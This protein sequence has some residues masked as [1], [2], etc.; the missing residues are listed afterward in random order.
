MKPMKPK[1]PFVFAALALLGLLPHIHADV[2]PNPLFSDNAVLQRDKKVQVWGVAAD[3]EKVTVEFAGQKV[4]TVAKDGKW[5]VELQQMPASAEPRTMTISGNNTITA[6]N[7]L[8]GEVWLCS[9]QSNMEWALENSTNGPEAVAAS[10]DPQLRMMRLPHRASDEPQSTFDAK[11]NACTPAS[12]PD[13]SAVA[14]HFGRDLRKSLGVP[15]GLIGSYFG[16]T[17]AESWTDRKTLETNPDLKTILEAH[18]RKI[19]EFDPVKMEETNKKNQADYEAALAKATAEG[20]K[21]PNRPVVLMPPTTDHRRPVGLYNGMIA[22]LQPYAIRGMIWYQGESNAGAPLLYRKLFPAMIGAWRKQWGEGDMPFLFAQIAPFKN[23]TPGIREAQLLAWKSTPRTAMV[24]T[25]DVGDAEDIHPLKKQPVGE[26]LALAARALAYGEQIVYSGPE[27][28]SMSVSGNRAVIHF[29]HTGSGLVAKDGDLRGFFLASADGNFRPAKA[30]I[31]G[32]T[33]EVF[34]DEVPVPAAVRYGWSNVPDVN[35]T[36][37]EGLPASPFRTDVS[38]SFAFRTGGTA[39][40]GV[41]LLAGGSNGNRVALA[42]GARWT[43]GEVEVDTTASPALWHSYLSTSPGQ[44]AFEPGQRY[45]ISYDYTVKDLGTDYPFYHAFEGGSA[46]GQA[47]KFHESWQ[48]EPNSK[49]NKEFTVTATIPDARLVIGVK[50]GAIRI[51]NLTVEKLA[52]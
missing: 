6:S 23:M 37:K 19:A 51:G 10:E 41:K 49:G 16:G 38:D 22:P 11:W 42:H 52:P 39:S 36:N 13:F 12:A 35:L 28:D 47:P 34:S 4:E 15:I 32:D 21:K 8:V 44:F 43:D 5:K 14:Y 9:G 29:K 45:R 46:D 3:G 40:G 2:V 48:A 31:K 24:V 33:V 25:T 17:P 7:I 50:K 30:E 20:T 27:Y 1:N 26:R 18:S